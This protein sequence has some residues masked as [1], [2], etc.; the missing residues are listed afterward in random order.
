VSTTA[1]AMAWIVIDIMMLQAILA[2]LVAA[3][4]PTSW[5]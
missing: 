3:A 5:T 2:A 4:H 1:P